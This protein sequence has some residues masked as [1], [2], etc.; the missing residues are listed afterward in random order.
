MRIKSL[1]FHKVQGTGIF[2]GS[3]IRMSTEE[4][5]HVEV[6]IQPPWGRR[7]ITQAFLDMARIVATDP[8]F[9]DNAWDRRELGDK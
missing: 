7:Q 3:Y 6:K 8:L 9:D 2:D 5:K 1:M 4:D